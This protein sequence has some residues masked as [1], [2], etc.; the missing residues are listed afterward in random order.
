MAVENVPTTIPS[1]FL[2]PRFG[3]GFGF[4][5]VVPCGSHCLYRGT[6][7]KNNTNTNNQGNKRTTCFLFVSLEMVDP[8][9]Y[10]CKYEYE[11]EYAR[12]A[13]IRYVMVDDTLGVIRLIRF[14]SHL[15]VMSV[16]LFNFI[17]RSNPTELNG[18]W[19]LYCQ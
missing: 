5:T 10:E 11:Y 19:Q 16:S 3:F 2:G 6:I 13:C 4:G 18:Q 14:Y 15:T 8:T 1:S 7:H 12:K 17:L 9:V